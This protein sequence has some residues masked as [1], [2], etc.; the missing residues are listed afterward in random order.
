MIE[1]YFT[2][3]AANRDDYFICSEC[4]LE[5]ESMKVVNDREDSD[6]I[7]ETKG[8]PFCFCPKCG[9]YI[10]QNDSTNDVE[11]RRIMKSIAG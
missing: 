7:D 9:K 10:I 6:E 8:N 1:K 3:N 11:F 2:L 5:I 4:R